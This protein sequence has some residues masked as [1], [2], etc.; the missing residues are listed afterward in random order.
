[1]YLVLSWSC[2]FP[3]IKLSGT[4][5]FC[6]VVY[7]ICL[8]F[9][10]SR[11][12]VS[13]LRLEAGTAVSPPLPRG[14]LMPDFTRALVTSYNLDINTPSAIKPI[15][16]I[17]PG[18][19]SSPFACT[20]LSS[21]LTFISFLAKALFCWFLPMKAYFP[22]PYSLTP[23]VHAFFLLVT[24]IKIT[25]LHSCFP[26]NI[27]IINNSRHRKISVDVNCIGKCLIWLA[28]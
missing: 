24:L 15:T 28:E 26:L 5:P 13:L 7:W 18:E 4:W 9:L 25:L 2:G 6:T 21:N 10:C 1:M 22:L 11:L 16:L 14:S 23:V 12:T 19:L 3:D 8:W 27:W 17:S 20:L